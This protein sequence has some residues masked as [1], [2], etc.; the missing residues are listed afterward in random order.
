MDM[1]ATR[2]RFR[3]IVKWTGAVL[4]VVILGGWGLSTRNAIGYARCDDKKMLIRSIGVQGGQ[5]HYVRHCYRKAFPGFAPP[6]APQRWVVESSPFELGLAFPSD[7]P[8]D[9]LRIVRVPLWL[10]FLIVALPTTFM[11]CRDRKRIPPGNC[12]KCGYNLTGAEHERCPECGAAC[13]A[14]GAET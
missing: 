7:V 11:F 10:P 14:C 12:R 3:R 4:C 1:K 9:T 8:A 5:V 6:W 13:E 2:S